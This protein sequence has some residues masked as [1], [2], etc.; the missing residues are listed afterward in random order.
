M[1]DNL[2]FSRTRGLVVVFM[3]IQL[4]LILL[5]CSENIEPNGEIDP[6]TYLNIKINNEFDDETLGFGS[7]DFT[8]TN[9][10]LIQSISIY[11]FSGDEP[12][13][14]RS[15]VYENGVAKV[16]LPSVAGNLSAFVIANE[17]ITTPVSKEDLLNRMTRFEIGDSGI[18]LTGMPMAS[19]EISF[20]LSANGQTNVKAEL[21]RCHST[22]YVETPGGSNKNYRIKL[23]GEQ[24]KQGALICGSDILAPASSNNLNWTSGYP[25]SD[26]STREVVTYY[27]PTDGEITIT[28]HPINTALP[29]INLKLERRKA[30]L[31]NRKYILRIIPGATDGVT[32]GLNLPN[33]SLVEEN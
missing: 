9:E 31:R 29:S 8:R 20:K 26:T 13:K 16:K 23:T 18:P 28:V 14:L 22:I 15:V 7:K 27:Y 17:T 30:V 5:S 32:K 24:R 25:L 6:G 4:G 11:I 33:V 10:D 3:I 19:S 12:V 2:S 1:T 21:V